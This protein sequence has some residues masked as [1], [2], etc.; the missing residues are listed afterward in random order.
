MPTPSF[1][2][3]NLVQVQPW[4]LRYLTPGELAS[5][6][7]DAENADDDI[8]IIEIQKDLDRREKE[9]GREVRDVYREEYLNE[10]HRR[11]NP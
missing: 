5:V 4:R 7:H 3:L 1:G 8:T 9:H 10:H 6:T 2:E 11:A